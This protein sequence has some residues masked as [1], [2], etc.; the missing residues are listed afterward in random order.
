MVKKGFWCFIVKIFYQ[1]YRFLKLLYFLFLI[2][3]FFKEIK[4]VGIWI[5]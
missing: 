2:L 1:F 3:A 5:Y 4:R